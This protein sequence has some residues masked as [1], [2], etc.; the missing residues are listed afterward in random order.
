VCSS[1]L[2]G[3]D[4][5]S[6]CSNLN[7]LI[8]KQ[9]KDGLLKVGYIGPSANFTYKANHLGLDSE[10]LIQLLKGKHPFS[11]QLKKAKNPYIILGE[12]FNSASVL[13]FFYKLVNSSYIQNLKY[14]NFNI[15]RTKSASL[16]FSELGINSLTSSKKFDL[17]FLLGVDDVK[18]YRLANPNSFI[19]Y[20]GSH[21]SVH[22]LEM[23][24]LIL[25]SSIFIEKDNQT[26]NL[27]NII[28]KRKYLRK[29]SSDIRSE[30]SL[31]L[32]I[33]SLFTNKPNLNKLGK[34]KIF[35]SLLFNKEYPFIVKNN[36]KLS[37]FNLRKIENVT[38]NKEIFSYSIFNYYQDNLILRSSKNFKFCLDNL[39]Q[40]KFKKKNV[41]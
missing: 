21:Y 13:N 14:S 12:R 38:L 37:E 26:T 5:R 29:M 23:A 36:F 4:L 9:V 20:M 1:D 15:M 10:S 28:K 33:I 41:V 35:D 40:V 18:L 24:D 19:I 32:V 31:L 8:K 16:S 7:L 3:S 30:Y 22:N 2:V 34:K 25:P 39:K 27:E 6:E 11:Y 17:L